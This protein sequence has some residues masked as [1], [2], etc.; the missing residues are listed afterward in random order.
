MIL[1]FLVHDFRKNIAGSFDFMRKLF[2]IHEM[3]R[4]VLCETIS[5]RACITYAMEKGHWDLV[6]GI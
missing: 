5:P 3:L 2:S 4:F 6:H 1:E